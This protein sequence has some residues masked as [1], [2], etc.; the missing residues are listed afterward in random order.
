MYIIFET[1]T[2]KDSKITLGNIPNIIVGINKLNNKKNS[3]LVISL[4]GNK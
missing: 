3:L 2:C 4:N 1:D